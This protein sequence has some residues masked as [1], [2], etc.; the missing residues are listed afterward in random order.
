MEKKTKEE[1]SSNHSMSQALASHKEANKISQKSENFRNELKSSDEL[2]QSSENAS[3]A[4][5]FQ[6][7]ND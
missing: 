7:L 5:V 4:S 2:K 3:M 6:D 1:F